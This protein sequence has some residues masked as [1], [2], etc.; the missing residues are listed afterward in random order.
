MIQI[1]P[2]Q[3]LFLSTEPV[4]FRKGIDTLAAVCRQK[5]QAD[6][7][8]GGFFVFRNRRRTAVK[9]LAYDGQGFWLFLK[10][11]SQG[12]LAWWP[13]SATPTYA[14]SAAHL[15]IL[16]SQGNPSQVFIPEDWRSIQAADCP[17][18]Y[19]EEEASIREDS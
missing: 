5:L 11:F 1:T 14:I 13:Q 4:D 17:D 10:R 15:Q 8:N 6:P 16:L 12:G 18:S 3:R 9:I 2:H 19:S 7:M